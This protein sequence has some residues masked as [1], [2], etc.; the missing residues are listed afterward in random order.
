VVRDPIR[1]SVEL[2]V[3]QRLG[4]ELNGD[5]WCVRGGGRLE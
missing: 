3:A 1:A 4:A 2:G 5:R